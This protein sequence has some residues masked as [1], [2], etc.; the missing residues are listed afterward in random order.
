MDMGDGPH[1]GPEL[2]NN[3]VE[4]AFLGRLEPERTVDDLSPEVHK[5]IAL[6]LDVSQRDP[7]GG[8][9][10]SVRMGDPDTDVSSGPAHQPSLESPSGELGQFLS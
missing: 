4:G 6:R 5:E 7:G 9:E 10:D 3:Q 8:D 2:I 1:F